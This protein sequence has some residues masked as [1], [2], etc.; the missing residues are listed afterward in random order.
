MDKLKETYRS[1]ETLKKLNLTVNEKQISD[2]RELEQIFFE[3]KILPLFKEI[4]NPILHERKCS[5]RLVL[6]YEPEKGFSGKFRSI[7][8]GLFVSED[9]DVISSFDYYKKMI[10][11]RTKQ[12]LAEKKKQG[13]KLGASNEKY[14]ANYNAK[15]KEEKNRIAQKRA[16]TRS[17]NYLRSRDIVTLLSIFK[18]VIPEACLPINNPAK[19]RWSLI[20]TKGDKKE[21][22]FALMRDFKELDTEGT[23]FRS[24]D[25]NKD[26]IHLQVKLSSTIF[27]IKQSLFTHPSAVLI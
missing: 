26:I 11:E 16:N 2:L 12:A 10:S 7:D 17:M 24:W 20:N 14:R 6:N 27:Q 15:S 4:L 1:F 22:I 25:F 8:T 21:R 23:L 13:A 19:W 3:E 18:T 5:Y 9:S